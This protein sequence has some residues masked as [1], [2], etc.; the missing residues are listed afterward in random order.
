M[1]L[2]LWRQKR[3]KNKPKTRNIKKGG[4]SNR[5][6]R[7]Y[8]GGWKP[9]ANDIIPYIYRKLEI[10]KLLDFDNKYK[11]GKNKGKPKFHKGTLGRNHGVHLV[12]PHHQ[13][14]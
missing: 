10:D 14:Q 6:T 13:N 8:R 11:S 4:A 7:R 5:Y 9:K 12:E 3:A 1:L 2:R